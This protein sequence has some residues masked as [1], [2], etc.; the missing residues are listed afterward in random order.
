VKLS[1]INTLNAPSILVSI[2]LIGLLPALY[3]AAAESAGKTEILLVASFYFF[4]ATLFFLA[5]RFSQKVVLFTLMCWAFESSATFAR[6]YRLRF[7]GVLAL[8]AAISE[9]IKYFRY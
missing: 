6:E 2:V 9:L 3:Y 5:K 1:E 4:L 8:C 7:Y